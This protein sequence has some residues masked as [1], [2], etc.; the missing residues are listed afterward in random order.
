MLLLILSNISLYV[1]RSF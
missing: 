1:F